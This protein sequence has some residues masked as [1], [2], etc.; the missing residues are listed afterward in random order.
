MNFEELL[1]TRD[2]RSTT[3]VRLPY[4]FFYK[5]LIGGKYSN[6]VEFHD[7]IADNLAFNHCVNTECEAV[8]KVNHKAQL[9]FTPNEGDDGVYAIAVE[10]GNFITMEQLLNETPSIVA[11]KEWM[12]E[13]LS[14]LLEL[15]AILNG[16]NI[17]HICFAPSNVLVRKNRN[18]VHLLCHG[19]FYRKIDEDILYDGLEDFVAPEVFNGGTV[20]ARTDVYS[21][22]KLIAFLYQSS[23]LPIELKN[24]VKK[25]TAEDPEKRYASVE[26]LRSAIHTSKGIYRT[27]IAGLSAMAVA[28]ICIGLFFYL[29]PSPETVEFVQP[30]EEPIP[31]E[32]VDESLDVLLGLGADADSAAI[33]NAM[34]SQKQAKDS[35]GVDEEK[36][37][38]YNAKAE[39]IFR[40]QFTKAAEAII[41][42]VYN[43]SSMNGE[44]SVFAA[45]SKAM[46]EELAKKQA[47]LTQIS[48]LKSEHTQ[49]IAAEVVEQITQKKREAME[50]DYM[51]IKNRKEEK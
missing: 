33:A 11:K 42:K 10:V 49:R 46:T 44:A 34:A 36:L 51:G 50:K 14:D 26:A 41:S 1:E 21:L 39:A 7:E 4:G 22:G 27:V 17:Y 24:V 5:R 18:T 28:L 8:A 29:L 6:F 40:K 15:T 31:D 23:G 35:L 12:N 32:M 48:T 30:V 16:Q 2:V 43:P 13:T 19:S 47:E 9:H 45:K 3:K 20:D 25:A 38:E 37:R